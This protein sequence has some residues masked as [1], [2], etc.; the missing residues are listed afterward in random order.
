MSRPSR[1]GSS[2]DEARDA[3]GHA[4]YDDRSPFQAAPDESLLRRAIPVTAEISRYRGL[5]AR[6]DAIAGLTVAALAIPSAMAYAECYFLRGLAAQGLAQPEQNDL[7]ER[8]LENA[9]LVKRAVDFGTSKIAGEICRQFKGKVFPSD[10]VIAATAIRHG[11]A[12]LITYYNT[13]GQSLLAC[14]GLIKRLDGG[15]LRICRPESWNADNSPQL[16]DK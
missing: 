15:T 11:A 6:K 5:I 1:S 12:A 13:A 14:D 7:I 4:S 3:S 9:Y 10:A 2:A 16:F 8:W